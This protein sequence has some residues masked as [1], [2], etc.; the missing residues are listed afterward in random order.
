M[1]LWMDTSAFFQGFSEDSD[2]SNISSSGF[3]K[4]LDAFVQL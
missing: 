3:S 2:S 4:K 1:E